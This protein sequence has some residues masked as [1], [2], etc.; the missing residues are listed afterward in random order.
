MVYL[1][2][3][4]GFEE[5]EAVTPVD[6]LRR[7]DVDVQIVGVGERLVEGAH[8]IVYQSDITEDEID[9]NLIDMIILPGGTEGTA[10]LENNDTVKK[11]ITFCVENQKPIA[12]ICAAPSILGKMGLLKNKKATCYPGLEHCLEGAVFGDKKVYADGLFITSKGPGTSMDF[13]LAIVEFLLGEETAKR[14]ASQ[15]QY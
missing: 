7:V 12:A 5:I 4:K 14:L 9:V 11:A 10:N 15:M 8:G 13:G 1:F 2:M 3:A 6:L